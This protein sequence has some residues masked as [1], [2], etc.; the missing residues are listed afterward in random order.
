LSPYN[1]EGT[2]HRRFQIVIAPRTARNAPGGAARLTGFGRFKTLLMG[3]GLATVA[4]AVLIAALIM[5]YILAAVLC[6]IVIL[7]VA[8][9]FVRLIF[10]PKRQ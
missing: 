3:F 5:G 7:V 6:I 10:V 9:S 4:L 2:M 8:V 1:M